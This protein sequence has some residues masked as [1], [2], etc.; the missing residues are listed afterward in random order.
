MPHGLCGNPEPRIG[1][2]FFQ[3]VQTK[4]P[5]GDKEVLDL[6]IGITK[7]HQLIDII[8]DSFRAKNPVGYKTPADMRNSHPVR[9]RYLSNMVCRLP[10][11]ATGH[12]F[13]QDSGISR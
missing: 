12:I 9:R 13:K 10:P 7:V 4:F 11:A 3:A 6:A 1:S 2:E 8:E 5:M